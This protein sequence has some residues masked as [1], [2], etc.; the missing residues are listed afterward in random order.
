MNKEMLIS[1]W[2][3]RIS[4]K[5]LE[6]FSSVP[7]E[8]FVLPEL[9]IRSYEDKPLP[10]PR[11]K[12]I[13]QPSTVLIMTEALELGEGQHVLEVG[14]GSGYQ[15][16]IIARMITPGELVSIE[17]LPELVQFSKQNLK[18]VGINNV[19]VIESDGSQGYAEKAPYDRIIVTA[20]MPSISQ[21]MLNQLKD[22]GVL[23][24]PVGDLKVQRM[25]KLTKRGSRM[26]QQDLGE[27]VFS[28][29]V[30]KFGFSEDSID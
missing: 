7:R 6:A 29:L 21:V 25:L 4:D 19:S 12:T 14:S 5:V 23:V 3:G 16:A 8:E 13:S 18:H 26:E 30:G 1:Y 20:A 15:S 22:G 24:A 27:F 11:G 28:P 9:R 10:I 2:H 17:V